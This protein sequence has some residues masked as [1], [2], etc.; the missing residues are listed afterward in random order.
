[1]AVAFPT[2]PIVSVVILLILVLSWLLTL[3]GDG[4]SI[5]ER[6]SLFAL[7]LLLSLFFSFSPLQL[8]RLRIRVTVECRSDESID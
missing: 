7:L 1:M 6:L 5:V 8:R 3:F 2:L 4:P